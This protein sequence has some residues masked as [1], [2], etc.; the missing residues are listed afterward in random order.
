MTDWKSH[1]EK[2]AD[3]GDRM[4]DELS[5]LAHTKGISRKAIYA[6]DEWDPARM[7]LRNATKDHTA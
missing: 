2:L 1:A 4:A 7:A 3:I 6:M 5:I